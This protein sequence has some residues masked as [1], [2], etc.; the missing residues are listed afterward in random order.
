[1]SG[2]I[3]GHTIRLE[4]LAVARG[5]SLVAVHV[6]AIIIVTATL[7]LHEP[8]EDETLDLDRAAGPLAPPL[9]SEV[10]GGTEIPT[11]PRQLT[12]GTGKV[13]AC[14]VSKS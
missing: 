1:M 11:I 7:S 10:T 14:T 9:P 4:I 13:P 3:I 8:T 2:Q 5:G 12:A 6:I